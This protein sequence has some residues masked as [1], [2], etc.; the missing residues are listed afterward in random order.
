M[1]FLFSTNL[2]S[3]TS[4]LKSL[5]ISLSAWRQERNRYANITPPCSHESGSRLFLT[6]YTHTSI[7]LMS[8][9][10]CLL[11]SEIHPGPE[12]S[13]F[14]NQRSR[15]AWHQKNLSSMRKCGR[16]TSSGLIKT[17]MD[18][19]GFS[20]TSCCSFLASRSSGCWSAPGSDSGEGRLELPPRHCSS[21]VRREAAL[22]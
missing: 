6:S 21:R 3:R 1:C 17:E 20:V 18:F 22:A 7:S 15:K 4:L 12:I 19:P 5:S 16:V 11:A 10:V 13:H 14:S 2:L 8:P 9:A